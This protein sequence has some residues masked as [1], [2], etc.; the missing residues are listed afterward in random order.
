MA[1]LETLVA[2]PETFIDAGDPR[3]ALYRV[4]TRVW[5]SAGGDGPAV[6]P[7][8]PVERSVD[9]I[10]PLPRQAFLLT[11][12]EGFG[13]GEVAR[14]LGLTLD[15]VADLLE[16]AGREIADQV[17]TDVLVIEDEPIIA[18][19]LAGLVEGLGH[20]VT[21]SAR[22]RAEAVDMARTRRP[23]LILA[24][25][26]LG[27]GSSGIDAVN[28]IIAGFD[29]PVVFITAYPERLLTGTRPE[30]AFLIT[31]PFQPHVVKAVISQ[32]LFFDTRARPGATAVEG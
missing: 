31:K 2:S 20:R 32:A 12:V 13:P 30:P 3:I 29:V 14:I 27:D 24:D 10:T 15:A 28:D 11:T 9:A 18:M 23:G 5:S 21:G 26:Q 25:I 7:E 8:D 16:A 4:F 6:P 19:D 22:T 17:A 1:V